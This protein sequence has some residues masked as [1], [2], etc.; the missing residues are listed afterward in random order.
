MLT[1]P[2]SSIEKDAGIN[3]DTLVADLR[4]RAL[5]WHSFARRRS[6]HIDALYMEAAA[7]EIERLREAV[8]A[9]ALVVIQ[10][11]DKEAQAQ[12]CA[13]V[14]IPVIAEIEARPDPVY[15]HVFQWPAQEVDQFVALHQP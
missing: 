3:P 9:P 6:D 13:S 14:G 15:G 1:N 12:F 5:M 7:A 2:P 4:Q 11:G 8:N 10:A